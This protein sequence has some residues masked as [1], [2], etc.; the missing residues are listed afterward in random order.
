MSYK[1]RAIRDKR[2]TLIIVCLVPLLAFTIILASVPAM[3]APPPPTP[4][5]DI[6]HSTLDIQACFYRDRA[7][8]CVNRPGAQAATSTEDQARALIKALLAGPTDDERA[9]G[10]RSA[11][12]Q[13]ARLTDISVAGDSITV[14]LV[15]P[16]TFLYGSLDPLVSDEIN[17]Q[18][19]KT[20]YPIEGL[21][22]FHVLALDPRDPHGA[23]KSLA[24]FLFE[25]RPA[26]KESAAAQAAKAVTTG[27]FL[28]GKAVY[29]SAGHGW[30][31]HDSFGEW[32]TQ[33]Y[34]QGSY[35]IIEDM[36]NA[37]VINQYLVQYLRN[38]GADVWP[39]REGT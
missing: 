23:F 19:I 24:Y 38:A 10:L 37:E 32:R 16:E 26:R 36:N 2:L 7:P 8:V 20:L 21:R 4:S 14:K 29:L 30:Y 6:R 9:S 5:F 12:P 31:W 28:S 15:L 35:E 17:A 34:A 18:I 1:Q 33:R 11:L 3:A 25:P 22:K 39:V 27:T 13:D